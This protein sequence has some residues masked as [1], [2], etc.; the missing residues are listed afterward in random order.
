MPTAAATSGTSARRNGLAAFSA[1]IVVGMVGLRARDLLGRLGGARDQRR[2]V[3][4]DRLGEAD[5]GERVFV[6]AIDPRLAAAD[7]AASAA[8]AHII[9]GV[10]SITRPQPIE[11]SVSPANASSSASNQ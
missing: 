8:T 7:R 9:S 11:N 5:I 1:P 2:V 4:L 3:R 10:P 6:T